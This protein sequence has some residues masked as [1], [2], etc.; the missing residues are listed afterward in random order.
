MIARKK[1]QKYRRIQ[2]RMKEKPKGLL[3]NVFS[4]VSLFMA[5]RSTVEG[6]SKVCF[7]S[8]LKVIITS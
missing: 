1:Q 4:L 5:S 3:L 7:K 2:L 8:T 6:P